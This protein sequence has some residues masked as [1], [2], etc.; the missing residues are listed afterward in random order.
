VS[1]VVAVASGLAAIAGCGA[2]VAVGSVV[3]ETSARLDVP[4]SACVA[5]AVLT[6]EDFEV[7]GAVATIVVVTEV[8][9]EAAGTLWS[10]VRTVGATGAWLAVVWDVAFTAA[11]VVAL[12][13]VGVSFASASFGVTAAAG[14]DVADWLAAIAAAAMA[15]GA[16]PLADPGVAAAGGAVTVETTGMTT[17]IA[18][19][20]VAVVLVP[21]CDV[22]SAEALIKADASP[23]E[24]AVDAVESPSE[25]AGLVRDRG[26]ASVLLLL[27]TSETGGLLVS[28]VP[29]LLVFAGGLVAADWRQRPASVAED[30]WSGRVCCCAGVVVA[31]AAVLLSTRPA[32]R[33]LPC[34]G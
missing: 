24:S 23:G 6:L 8:S 27:L 3:R 9:E 19:G 5:D 31:P 17:A 2:T 29:T 1:A 14:T 18:T 22:G 20:S 15:R 30:E 7:T 16:V 32:K 21:S 4:A 28:C 13:A 25:D 34:E 26:G 33:S 11:V 12:V 10:A